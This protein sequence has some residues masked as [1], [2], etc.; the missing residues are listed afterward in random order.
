MLSIVIP[1]YNEEKNLE[2]L[3]QRFSSAVSNKEIEVIFVN[4]GSTDGSE[5]LF[6]E[7]LSQYKF[8]KYVHV[9]KNIGYGH[10]IISGLKQCTMPF[11]GWTHADLQTDPMDVAAAYELLDPKVKNIYIK[12]NRQGRPIFDSFFTYAM[13]FFETIYLRKMLFD[14]N[15]Q[16]NIFHRDFFQSWINPP[17]DFSLD[18][19][20]LYSAKKKKLDIKR[21]KVRFPNRVHGISSWNHGLQS[22]YKFIKRTL[23]FSRELKGRIQHEL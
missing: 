14:I 11:I 8:A 12:G 16:P 9:L 23:L 1:C 2:N 13:S 20:A 10:G 6:L 7:L 15:A 21:I 18:L 22:K 4:N 5:K 19:F 17:N 3:F